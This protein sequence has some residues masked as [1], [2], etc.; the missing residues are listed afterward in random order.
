VLY[1]PAMILVNSPFGIAN[2]AL[3][4]ITPPQMRAQVAAFYMLVVSIGMMLGPPLAGTFNEQI[5]PGPDGVRYS[6]I[7]LTAIFGTLGVLLLWMARGFYAR[8]MAEADGWTS[9]SIGHKPEGE[10]T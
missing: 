7:S 5:F 8:S 1:V 6:L 10:S 4:V 3:P 2:A 9:S